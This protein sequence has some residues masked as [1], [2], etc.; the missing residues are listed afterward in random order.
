RRCLGTGRD[1]RLDLLGRPVPHDD[2]VAD[3]HEAGRDCG[4][5]TTQSGDA[6]THASF[7]SRWMAVTAQHHTKLGMLSNVFGGGSISGLRPATRIDP[8]IA[9]RLEPD[10]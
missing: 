8:G 5:H 10:P 3:L 7:S 2:L 4:P 9:H 1:E 6:D